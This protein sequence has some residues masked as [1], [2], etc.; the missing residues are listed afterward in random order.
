[1][2]QIMMILWALIC[3]YGLVAAALLFTK[4]AKPSKQVGYSALGNII[5][6]GG[7]GFNLA[8][9]NFVIGIIFI[10]VGVYFNIKER[11]AAQ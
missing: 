4:K 11:D 9:F 6:A 10:A 3:L 7:A 2:S 8:G 1:M 5:I